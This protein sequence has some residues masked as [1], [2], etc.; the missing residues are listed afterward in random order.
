M[1]VDGNSST[2]SDDVT[3]ISRGVSSLSRFS[4]QSK[5]PEQSE[6]HDGAAWTESDDAKSIVIRVPARG[7]EDGDSTS[8]VSYDSEEPDL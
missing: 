8:L 6:L 3:S 2:A 7:T 5:S 4:H 1:D